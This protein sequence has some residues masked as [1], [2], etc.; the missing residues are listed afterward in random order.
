M[1][2]IECTLGIII[3]CLLSAFAFW[4]KVLRQRHL[5]LDTLLAHVAGQRKENQRQL[6]WALQEQLRLQEESGMR[7]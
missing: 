4:R 7:W 1:L 6:Q 5:Y 3:F 2:I